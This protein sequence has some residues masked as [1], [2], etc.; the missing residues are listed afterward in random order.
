MF[1]ELTEET[2]SALSGQDT[3]PDQ[4][5]GHPERVPVQLKPYI[6]IRMTMTGRNFTRSPI[7]LTM[8]A[9]ALAVV[10]LLSG[11]AAT[12]VAIAKRD[13]DVQTKMS[14][15][16]FL[17]PVKTADRTVF[18][19]IRNTSDKQELDVT[20]D[21]TQAIAAKGYR[22]VDDPDQAQFYLQV[23]VLHVGKSSATASQSMLSGG[24][25]APLAGAAT[26]AAAVGALGGGHPS[27]RAFATGALAGGLIE[28]VS[29]AMVKDVY[30][31]MATDIQVKQRLPK[32]K[33]ATL[34]SSH[35]LAQGTSGSESVNF[36]DSVDMKAYQTRIVS[37][38]NKMNLEFEEAATPLRQGLIRSL[39]G[40]F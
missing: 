30:Y 5:L 32:G 34:S 2:R 31:S 35:K 21:I 39:S 38:A 14:A 27:G 36:Q 6:A 1:G 33:Q 22:I 11:C 37:T 3:L 15:T 29:G 18:L 9:A 25:G 19:Q 8:A 17:D 4:V 13:L 7:R 20:P 23:N 16:I 26:G 28:A 12:Q 10:T 24:Y 40:L